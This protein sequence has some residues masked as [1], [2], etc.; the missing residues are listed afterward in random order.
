MPRE[1]KFAEVVVKTNLI[2][3]ILIE[4]EKFYEV[5]FPLQIN[6][7][8]HNEKANFFLLLHFTVKFKYWLKFMEWDRNVQL[9]C[10]IIS[11]LFTVH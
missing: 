3:I 6:Q 11:V 10:G 1:S 7:K 2:N 5:L 4:Y 8:F 9:Q